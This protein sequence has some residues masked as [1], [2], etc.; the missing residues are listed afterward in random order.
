M[1]APRR[2]TAI[3]ARVLR[4]YPLP[5][6]EPHAGGESPAPGVPASGRVSLWRP[7]PGRLAQ[8]L[9]GLFVFGAGE[10]LLIAATLGNSP[11]SVFAAGAGERTGVSVGVATIAISVLVLLAWIPLRQPPGLGTIANALVVGIAIDVVLAVLPEPDAIVLRYA[12][13]LAGIA[14]VG[15]GSALYLGANLGPG[16]R[17]GLWVAIHRRYGV[18]PRRT[19]TVLEVSAVAAGVALGGRAGVGTIAFALLVG[20]AVHAAVTLLEGDAGLRHRLRRPR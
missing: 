6:P 15:I 13:V 18:S 9:A 5:A 19:R 20:P 8:L 11:W 4:R 12:F 1:G 17:D 2:A 14:V 3:I 7:S 10:A 16:P